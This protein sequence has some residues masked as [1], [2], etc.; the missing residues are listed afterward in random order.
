[1]VRTL[2]NLCIIRRLEVY[3]NPPRRLKYYCLSQSP[4]HL[5]CA[6]MHMQ[7]Q[8]QHANNATM[9]FAM[10]ITYRSGVGLR[11]P[12]PYTLLGIW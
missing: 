10:S 4:N 7:Q 8:K 2:E 6:Y 9:I 12:V 1:M 11:L 3:P 5:P